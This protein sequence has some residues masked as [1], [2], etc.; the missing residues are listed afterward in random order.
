MTFKTIE[1]FNMLN[2]RDKTMWLKE[3]IIFA[4]LND[5]YIVEIIDYFY[6]FAMTTPFSTISMDMN[7]NEW[8][9]VDKI[10]SSKN[11]KKWNYIKFTL[12]SKYEATKN[13]VRGVPVRVVATSVDNYIDDE[14]F[15]IYKQRGLVEESKCI[16][17]KN[18]IYI[19]SPLSGKPCRFY[20]V[21]KTVN[22]NYLRK[23]VLKR[24]HI[25]NMF[26]KN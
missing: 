11:I 26:E 9:I 15:K 24:N 3:E 12:G 22:T 25:V 7:L 14:M 6:I 18:N 13:N 10:V 2:A 17:N 20:Y 21:K 16:V 23:I 8:K 19:P 5:E 4:V 1:E